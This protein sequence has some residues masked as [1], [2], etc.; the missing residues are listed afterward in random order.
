MI[1]HLYDSY[2][3]MPAVIIACA[4]TFL[5]LVAWKSVVPV[6]ISIW[7]S[8]FA[9]ETANPL[10]LLIIGGAFIGSIILS[11]LADEIFVRRTDARYESL[12]IDLYR[13]L[14]QKRPEFYQNGGGKSD[15]IIRSN[16]DGTINLFRKFRLTILDYLATLLVPIAIIWYFNAILGVIFAAGVCLRALVSTIA[17]LKERPLRRASKEAYKELTSTIF[18][19]MS[20]WAIVRLRGLTCYNINHIKQLAKKEQVLFRERHVISARLEVFGDF[21]TAFL[22]IGMFSVIL[23]YYNDSN[24]QKVFIAALSSIY[25]LN[26]MS[27]AR[28]FGEFYKGWNERWIEVSSSLEELRSAEDFIYSQRN[29]HALASGTVNLSKVSVYYPISGGA[30]LKALSNVNLMIENGEHVAVTGQNASGK[31][32]LSRIIV[33]LEDR[34]DG[35]GHVGGVNLSGLKGDEFYRGI[36]FVPQEPKLFNRTTLDNIIYFA[37]EAADFEIADVLEIVGLNLENGLD[38]HRR[39]GEGGENLSGGQRQ[40]V[41]IAR[42]LL[43]KNAKVFVFDEPTSALDRESA[44]SITLKIMQYLS[45]RTLIVITHDKAIETLFQRTI[46]LENGKVISPPYKRCRDANVW[47]LQ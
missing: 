2:G 27:A 42:A 46:R 6:L 18:Q 8:Q 10:L 34:F 12:V 5:Y 30:R 29:D 11:I 33:G 22:F 1:K 13:K 32:T 38:L 40:R 20:N 21:I 31:S 19:D 24:T 26:S 35:I 4:L 37:P 23:F 47:G 17:A 44:A 14:L 28:G 39:V 36:S 43:K 7:V 9:I 25:I 3:K 41:A 16:L 15:A 45:K